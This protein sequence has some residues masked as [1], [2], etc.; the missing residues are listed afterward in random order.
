MFW[1]YKPR[2]AK[3]QAEKDEK[4]AL[5]RLI[6]FGVGRHKLSKKLLR[7]HLPEL[8]IDENKRAALELL[9]WNKKF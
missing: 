3:K 8:R 9:V 5:E 4:W 7:K 6:N 2:A 1:D